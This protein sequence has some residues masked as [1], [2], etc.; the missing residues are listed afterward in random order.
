MPRDKVAGGRREQN[1]AEKLKRIKEVAY[2]LFATRGYDQ[3]T[4]AQIAHEAGIGIATLFF[5]ADDKRDL[6]FLIFNEW[7]DTVLNEMERTDF[8]ESK[9]VDALI[10]LLRPMYV[11]H[12]RSPKLS[13][14]T[15]RELNFFSSGKHS[16]AFNENNRRIHKLI[17]K[18]IRICIDRGEVASDINVEFAVEIVFATYQA[19]IR[20]FMAEDTGSIEGALDRLAR[21]F[22][23]VVSGLGMPSSAKARKAK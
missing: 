7:F 17:E 3:T 13:R 22:A 4:T 23:L 1:K 12:R 21:M 2:S 8:S 11:H 19:E 16:D 20:H 5:Y 14:A 6:L 15:L 10:K 18:I 9:M